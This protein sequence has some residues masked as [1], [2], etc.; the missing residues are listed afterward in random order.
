MAGDIQNNVQ[1]NL[2]ADVDIE[3]SSGMASLDEFIQKINLV[4]EAFTNWSNTTTDLEDKIRSKFDALSRDLGKVGVSEEAIDTKIMAKVQREIN[5]AITDYVNSIDFHK[6]LFGTENLQKEIKGLGTIKSKLNKEIDTIVNDYVTLIDRTR[7]RANDPNTISKLNQIKTSVITTRDNIVSTLDKVARDSTQSYENRIKQIELSAQELSEAI[8]KMTLPKNKEQTDTLK[9]SMASTL[10]KYADAYTVQ[11]KKIDQIAKLQADSIPLDAISQKAIE[12]IRTQVKEAIISSIQLHITPGALKIKLDKKSLD[13]L[14]NSIASQLNAIIQGKD[15]QLTFEEGDGRLA[16]TNQTFQ[17]IWNSIQEKLT[18]LFIKADLAEISRLESFDHNRLVEKIDEV[19][20]RIEKIL[21]DYLDSIDVFE[22]AGLKKST[23]KGKKATVSGKVEEAQTKTEEIV[24]NIKQNTKNIV[25]RTAKEI[26]DELD[27]VNDI[28]SKSKAALSYESVPDDLREKLSKNLQ[29]AIKKRKKLMRELAKIM[30]E[31]FEPTSPSAEEKAED[32]LTSTKKTYLLKKEYVPEFLKK[33]SAKLSEALES[34]SLDQLD[35]IKDKLSKEDFGFERLSQLI[36]EIKESVS[37]EAAVNLKTSIT[38]LIDVFNALSS[39]LSISDDDKAKILGLVKID[40]STLSKLTKGLSKSINDALKNI[41]FGEIVPIKA[42]DFKD[43]IV[44]KLNTILQDL[45]GAL[46]EIDS[47]DTSTLK[48][49]AAVLKEV[50]TTQISS[51]LYNIANEISSMVDS[52]SLDTKETSE[53]VNKLVNNISKI[54][55]AVSEGFVVNIDSYAKEFE[56]IGERLS[57]ANLRGLY[58]TVNDFVGL[59]NRMAIDAEKLI[60]EQKS[61]LNNIITKIGTSEEAPAPT[62]GKKLT[63]AEKQALAKGSEKIENELKGLTLSAELEKI[64]EKIKALG[65][66]FNKANKLLSDAI[67]VKESGFDTQIPI[68]QQKMAEL[69]N[70]FK[71][72]T[73]SLKG[74]DGG[75]L[76]SAIQSFITKLNE[77]ESELSKVSIKGVSFSGIHASLENIASN[78]KELNDMFNNVDNGLVASRILLRSTVGITES[79]ASTLR[80]VSL[81]FGNMDNGVVAAQIVA[82]SINAKIESFVHS[83]QNLSSKITNIDTAQLNIK[84]TPE[85]IN[86]L[87]AQLEGVSIVNVNEISGPIESALKNLLKNTGSLIE[88]HVNTLMAQPDIKI[89]K[90]NTKKIVTQ[91]TTLINTFIEGYINTVAE[92]AI[93]IKPFEIATKDLPKGIQAALAK[94]AEMP[95]ADYIKQMPRVDSANV[96]ALSLEDNLNKL[97]SKFYDIIMSNRAGLFRGIDDHIKNIKITPDLT[98]IEYLQREFLNTQSTIVNKIKEMLRDQFS[99]INKYI[100]E[101]KVSPIGFNYVPTNVASLQASAAN[102]ANSIGATASIPRGNIN[103]QYPY[104][105]GEDIVVSD[106][107]KKSGGLGSYLNNNR[108]FNSILNTMRYI[109]AGTLV[110]MPLGSVREAWSSTKSLELAITRAANNLRGLSVEEARAYTDQ[111][112]ERMY[113]MNLQDQYDYLKGLTEEQAKEVEYKRIS[114]LINGGIKESLQSLALQYIIPQ[115]TVGEMYQYATRSTRNPYE[116]LALTR[117]AARLYAAEPEVGTAESV[118][119]ALQSLSVIWGISGFD[120][121]KYTSMMYAISSQVSASAQDVLYG[122]VAGGATLRQ[123]MSGGVFEHPELQALK[124]EISRTTDVQTLR[125]LKTKYEDLERELT[126]AYSLPLIALFEEATGRTGRQTGAAFVQIFNAFNREEVYKAIS[127]F[128]AGRPE[129]EYLRPYTRVT[130]ET[131]G[132]VR[133]VPKNQLQVLLEFLDALPKLRQIDA[134]EVDEILT[135]I[136]GRYTGGIKALTSAIDEF[137]KRYSDIYGDEGG[138]GMYTKWAEDIRASSSDKLTQDI[139]AINET[140]AKRTQQIPIMWGIA[141]DEVSQE[142]KGEI[143]FIIDSVMT[144]LRAIHD[145]AEAISVIIK[146]TLVTLLGY[147]IRRLGGKAYDAINSRV[148]SAEREELLTPFTAKLQEEV[149]KRYENMK[150]L[151]TVEERMARAGEIAR[152]ASEE[153]TKIVGLKTIDPVTGTPVVVAPGILDDVQDKIKTLSKKVIEYEELSRFNTVLDDSVDNLPKEEVVS[154]VRSLLPGLYAVA[155]Q[156]LEPLK[157]TLT[158][159]TDTGSPEY[160]MMAAEYEKAKT[161]VYGKLGITAIE[162]IIS[163]YESSKIDYSQLRSAVLKEMI[164]AAKNSALSRNTVLG[165]KVVDGQRVSITLADR[166]SEALIEQSELEK[167]AEAYRR[168]YGGDSKEYSVASRRVDMARRRVA[169]LSAGKL[170]N[171]EIEELQKELQREMGSEVTSANIEDRKATL[172]ALEDY[173]IILQNEASKLEN[174]QRIAEDSLQGLGK[175]RANI[176]KDLVANNENIN[177]L[178]ITIKNITEAYKSMGASATPISATKK[179]ILSLNKTVELTK[180]GF[181]KTLKTLGLGSSEEEIEQTLDS[182]DVKATE[183][184]LGRNAPSVMSIWSFFKKTEDTN[185]RYLENLTRQE[186]IKERIRELRENP[187][188]AGLPISE[189]GTIDKEGIKTSVIAKYERLRKLALT[190]LEHADSLSYTTPEESAKRVDELS[191]KITDNDFIMKEVDAQLEE[192]SKSK[193]GSELGQLATELAN[194]RAE[195]EKLSASSRSAASA[196]AELNEELRRANVEYGAGKSSEEYIKEIKESQ[197]LETTSPLVTI[198]G[199]IFGGLKSMAI[200]WLIGTI[201]TGV[202]RLI[203]EAL[204]PKDIKL[205]R[206]YESVQNI[207]EMA[208]ASN[209]STAI[210]VEKFKNWWTTPQYTVDKNGQTI[211]YDRNTGIRLPLDT[212]SGNA[213]T[214]SSIYKDRLLNAK[215]QE[216]RDT[217]LKEYMDWYYKQMT[218]VYESETR[219]RTIAEKQILSAFDKLDNQALEYSQSLEAIETAIEY[220]GERI[221]GTINAAAVKYETDRYNATLMGYS[222]GS[223][224]MRR[225]EKEFAREQLPVYERALQGI[226]NMMNAVDLSLIGKEVAEKEMDEKGFSDEIKYLEWKRQNDTDFMAFRLENERIRTLQNTYTEYTKAIN[227]LKNTIYNIF[228]D[229]EANISYINEVLNA[230]TIKLNRL[231]IENTLARW[232]EGIPEYSARAVEEEI[233]NVYQQYIESTKAEGK[234]RREFQKIEPTLL[235][236][237]E[238]ARQYFS[239][240]MQ[241]R[242]A[243]AI[244]EAQQRLRDAQDAYDLRRSELEQAEAQSAEALLRYNQERESLKYSASETR[245]N[246]AAGRAEAEARIAIAQAQL[247]GL[248]EDSLYERLITRQRLEAQNSILSVRINEL[249][250]LINE[251]SPNAER[252]RVEVLDLL[253]QQ[254]ENLVAIRK[255]NEN[256]VSFGMPEG[257]T[258]ITYNSLLQSMATERAFAGQRNEILVTVNFNNANLNNSND[259]RRVERE[260]TD[261]INRAVNRS[262]RR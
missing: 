152:Q 189:Y 175:S 109:I 205:R 230:T 215:T 250:K 185:K 158:K 201:V 71:G 159:I 130:D 259:M 100:K 143:N 248:G 260:L 112:I 122:M 96:V 78:V 43:L 59:L 98:V 11:L 187:E 246:L 197:K 183:S 61:G 97:Y 170:S 236:N 39:A 115:E 110:K 83:L 217:I 92:N 182:G 57:Q 12:N 149:K 105:V 153:R 117:A 66:N 126:F 73:T 72:I 137:Q 243:N 257:L 154:R 104:R 242:D 10:K 28:L 64:T 235:Q 244:Q 89:P 229:F 186:S 148:L 171:T 262:I 76:A 211:V 210:G 62:K 129:L 70:L 33:V 228:E 167:T 150:R 94:K 54:K 200:S 14:N 190:E 172:K 220:W 184:K 103:V 75:G 48:E 151:N 116:A 127:D 27:E 179:D 240:A 106:L 231:Q 85:Q 50:L 118:A 252:Y 222:S 26:Q 247:R 119:E 212:I 219:V 34:V 140:M 224:T 55:T 199:S 53:A 196:Q 101:L 132:I 107:Y 146:N 40:K 142:F 99:E 221:N 138:L 165:T 241:I 90:L 38:N 202:T 69:G 238:E 188:L 144:L 226:V 15:F 208:G 177:E 180:K 21:F 164:D 194:L 193:A 120:I 178:E 214:V 79:V 58:S 124:E 24:E 123:S 169:M 42:D 227:G 60:S 87:E 258:V 68:L 29:D 136:A 65:E 67:A 135:K 128:V 256:R 216:E 173:Y 1:H 192:I 195:A 102:L 155:D 163:D 133:E 46:K 225:I 32:P 41:E 125:E 44:V 232:Q 233:N 35:A 191:K 198:A 7:E 213:N 6:A 254:N 80:E 121:D 245:Y 49:N 168:Q 47:V 147:G 145:N 51:M 111:R 160:R 88:N 5:Q 207:A 13:I 134:R 23:K 176:V 30:S 162:G 239:Y 82:N 234:I 3:F 9:R 203:G 20:G 25:T 52:K 95:I 4:N 18:D 17:N 157:N 91:L 31:D 45:T 223:P 93:T 204:M 218:D 113:E 77:V 81:A 251:G 108:V 255:L 86:G 139:M 36:N 166:L 156:E 74:L 206:S 131:T 161:K 84:L 174:K 56:R 114:D 19:K 16:I 141:F 63:K 249:Q 253:A 181:L 8:N 209:N 37:V 261:A 2:N 22:A 237:I